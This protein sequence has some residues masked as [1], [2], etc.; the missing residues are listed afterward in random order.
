LIKLPPF[1]VVFDLDD[2]LISERDYH[3]SGIQAVEHYLYNLYQFPMHGVLTDAHKRGVIDIWGYASELLEIPPTISESLLWIYRNHTPKIKLL[4]GIFELVNKL[5]C[6]GVQL[7][8]LTDGRSISQRLKLHSVGLLNL[9]LY[10][11]EEWG[12]MKPDQQRFKAIARRWP[13][14][15]YAYIADNAAKDFHAP[16][17]LGWTT[18]GARWAPDPI[19]TI[20]TTCASA[21]PV[22]LPHAWLDHPHQV[23]HWLH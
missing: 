19:H 4:P 8:I 10:I 13:N 11:S 5:N 12:D 2:T 14:S 17:Q 9:P 21:I 1:I 20:D 23:L 3:Y 6:Q 18:L 16:S 22:E 15:R 7:A